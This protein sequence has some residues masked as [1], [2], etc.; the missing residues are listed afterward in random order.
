MIFVLFVAAAMITLTWVLG[1]WG[2]LV[3]ALVIGVVFHEHGGGGWR[4]AAAA[5]VAWGTLLVADGVVGPL[6]H[7]ATMLGG[8]MSVPAAGVL[9]LTLVF[10]AALAW[11]AA[12]IAA[13][14]RRIVGSRAS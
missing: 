10:P 11:S 1:W 9:V 6:G 2:I 4:V 8:V 12:T 13:E 5:S 3:V 7:L 14:S